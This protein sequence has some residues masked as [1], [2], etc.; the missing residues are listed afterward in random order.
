MIL[1]FA[2]FELYLI[3]SILEIINT[4]LH[5]SINIISMIIDYNRRI[6][7]VYVKLN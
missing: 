5:V 2:L 7:G 1:T 4:Y 6:V 3:I